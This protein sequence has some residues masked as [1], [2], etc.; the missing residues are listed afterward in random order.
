MVA[1]SQ[2]RESI[3]RVHWPIAVVLLA[4]TLLA[5]CGR[6]PDNGQGSS[7]S[8]NPASLTSSPQ[9][10][11]PPVILPTI[12]AG[13]ATTSD[14]NY[15][16]SLSMSGPATASAGASPTYTLTYSIRDKQGTGVFISWS[17]ARVVYIGSSV[18]QGSAQ[19]D[20]PP[21]ASN[22]LEHSHWTIGAPAGKV[23][24]QLRFPTDWNGTFRIGAYEP[25]TGTT[26]SNT[27]ETVVSCP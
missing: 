16:L 1:N 23:Q 15:Y 8:P 27:V 9:A 7:R 25:G 20:G 4:S 21:S 13:A 10:C 26:S 12:P 6:S 24:V 3:A 22:G 2:R 5:A 14:P 19:E 17:D 18:I 11:A